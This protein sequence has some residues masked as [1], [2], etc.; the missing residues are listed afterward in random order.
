[1]TC[2]NPGC[3]LTL[4]TGEDSAKVHPMTFTSITCPICHMI[5]HNPMDVAEGYCGNCH[6]WTAPRCVNCEAPIQKGRFVW[7]HLNGDATHRA[8]PPLTP[9]KES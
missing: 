5:S 4:S 7:F 8:L 2:G 9:T 6:A 3:V 1:V